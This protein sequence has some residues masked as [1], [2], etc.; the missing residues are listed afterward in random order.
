MWVYA[1]DKQFIGHS[2]F[3]VGFSGA[4]SLVLQGLCG[5]GIWGVAENFCTLLG[6]MGGW[7]L[8]LSASAAGRRLG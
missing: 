4:L 7:V 6:Y 2:F 5:G 8:V 1:L 3:C